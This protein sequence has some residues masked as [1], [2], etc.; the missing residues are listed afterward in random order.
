MR[1]WLLKTE[2]HTFSWDDQVARGTEP[3]T[4][5][6]NFQAA[7]NMK[8]MAL[9]DRCFFYHSGEG[10]EVVGIVEVAKL[11]ARDPTDA[12]GKFGM[13]E[14]RTVA[15]FKRPVTLAEIKADPQ[16]KDMVL[17]RNARLSVQPV[18]PAAWAYICK[19]GGAKP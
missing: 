7:A 12:T 6:R 10:K 13:V 8:A 4:G 2:P 11:Y 17:V 15:P 5:V 9:G 18:E 3:W 16:L 19:L 1:Y 14:V